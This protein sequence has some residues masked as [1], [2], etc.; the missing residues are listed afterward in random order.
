[1]A[2]ISPK[3]ALNVYASLWVSFQVSGFSKE[4]AEGAVSN[5]NLSQALSRLKRDGWLTIQLDPNDGRKS[6]YTL[7]DPKEV[8]E[9]IANDGKTK[10]KRP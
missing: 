1:M 6:L 9:E 5:P 10:D 2:N 4:R 8:I 3:W 7:K